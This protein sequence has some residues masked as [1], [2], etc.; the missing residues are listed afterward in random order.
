M[1]L[2]KFRRKLCPTLPLSPLLLFPGLLIL[3]ERQ[4]LNSLKSLSLLFIGVKIPSQILLWMKFAK[5]FPK[6]VILLLL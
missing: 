4:L 5:F 2:L 6:V 3:N 1:P